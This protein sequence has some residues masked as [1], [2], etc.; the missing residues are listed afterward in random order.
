MYGQ[1]EATARMSYVPAARALEKAGSIGVAIPGGE[2]FLVDQAGGEIT[3]ADV[4]GELGYRGPNVTMGYAE[5]RADLSKGDERQGSLRTGDLALRDA[6]GYYYITGRLSRMAKL[7]GKRVSLD[8][9]EQMC[10]GLVAEVA[11]TG[12]E[13]RVTVWIT[14]VQHQAAL[15]GLLAERTAIHPSAYQV[16]VI[17]SLPRTPAGKTDYQWLLNEV[18][19]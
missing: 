11:C 8:D 2:L 9:L 17:G 3:A 12:A 19:A 6:D 1:T 4:Q 10:L 18:L 14:D 13:D 15:P 7:F 5:Q 16:R